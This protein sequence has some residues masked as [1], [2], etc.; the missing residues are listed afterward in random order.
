MVLPSR[1]GPSQT[2]TPAARRAPS[3]ASAVPLPPEMT[4][5]AWPMR[6][7]G[8]AVRPAMKPTTGFDMCSF[9]K[10]APLFL[11]GAANLADH[12]HGVGLRVGLEAGKAVD[13]VGAVDWVAADARQ[14]WTG[15]V[16]AA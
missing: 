14:P 9:T 13:E 6:L 1:C 10:A 11:F 5:P 7:P 4:A 2:V 16:R 12:D 3:F 15:R 8:G